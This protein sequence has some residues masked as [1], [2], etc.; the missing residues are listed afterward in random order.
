M[1]PLPELLERA[2]LYGVAPVW[3][4]AGFAD[5]ACHRAMRIEHSAGV[6]ESLL[7]LFM[8]AELGIGV[9]CALLLELTTAAFAIILLACVAHEVT[10]CADLAYAESQRR[11][12]WY[13][14]WVH[15][16]QQAVPWVAVGALMLLHAPQA[17][18]LFG[19]GDVPPDWGLRPK[20][21]PLP[22]WYL[23]SFFG[24]GLLLVIGPFLQEFRR[25]WRQ[26]APLSSSAGTSA[27][28]GM[29]TDADW[30]VHAAGPGAA[31]IR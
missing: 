6:R 14:Q 25:C 24:S 30:P 26:S 3:I 23:V 29:D 7:H 12:P 27:G 22:A 21:A 5:F 11:I 10:M 31:R 15:G 20:Q 2:L 8:L 1:E 17:M 28:T 19:L 13:E 4:L 16:L 18:A 9:L